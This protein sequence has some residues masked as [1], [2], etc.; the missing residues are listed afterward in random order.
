[1]SRDRDRQVNPSGEFNIGANSTMMEV[2]SFLLFLK[3]SIFFCENPNTRRTMKLK[4]KKKSK[5]EKGNKKGK[6]KKRR[7]K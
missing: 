5:F 1:M 2:I 7:R 4:F 3:L 6:N